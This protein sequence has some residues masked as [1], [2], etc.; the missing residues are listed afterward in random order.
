ME[1][2]PNSAKVVKGSD[3]DP[4]NVVKGKRNVIDLDEY[5]ERDKEV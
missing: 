4:W 3:V 2:M 1:E 5:D